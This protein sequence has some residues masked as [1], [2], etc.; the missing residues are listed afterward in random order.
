M[1]AAPKALLADATWFGTLAAARD[2]AAHDVSVTLASDSWAAPARWSRH[3]SNVVACP[4]SKRASAFLAW[5]LGFGAEQPGMVLYPTSDETAWLIASHRE[6]LSRSYILYSPPIAPLIKILDKARLT[7]EAQKAGLDVPEETVPR[8]EAEVA[9]CCRDALFPLYVKPRAQTFGHRVGKGV[10]VDNPTQ[11]LAAWREQTA[12]VTYDKEVVRHIPDIHLP[13]LQ[14]CIPTGGKIYT[15]DGFIDET[16]DL[17]AML[18]CVKVLQRPRGSGPGI[19]FEHADMDPEIEQGLIRLFRN[20]GFYGVFDAEFLE[21]G[22]RKMLIDIN[23]RFY[24]HM[25]FE[26]E[27]GLHLPWLSYLAATKNRETLKAEIERAR[28]ADA[29]RSAYVHRLPIK[30]LLGMQRLAGRMSAE[31][32]HDWRRRI[33]AYGNAV[34]DPVRIAGDHTPAFAE[35]AMEVASASRH[36]RSYFRSLLKT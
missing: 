1:S 29:H 8:D 35:I 19:V 24:N 30:L 7:E 23:P 33:S 32:A 25:A 13:I 5:L 22:S 11:L 16:G 17:S 9:Q 26:T 12:S 10:R 27:R 6:E 3:V 15:V 4:T 36:P 2:L 31:D 18:A 20:T 21:V 34:T 28:T 14:R